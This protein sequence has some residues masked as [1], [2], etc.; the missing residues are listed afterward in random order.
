MFAAMLATTVAATAAIT[1]TLTKGEEERKHK[2]RV[3]RQYQRELMLK[4][5]TVVARLANKEPPRGK[6]ID[7][8]FI[9]KVYLW[10]CQDLRKSFDSA[11]ITNEMKCQYIKI[12]SPVRA[13]HLEKHGSSPSTPYI[14]LIT[15]HECILGEVVRKPNK[16]PRTVAYMRAGPRR[17][18][19]FDPKTVNAAIVTCGG[20]CPGLNNVIRE[21]TKS[22]HQL[23]GIG[24][25]VYGIQGGFRGFYDTK[26]HLQPII[27][28]PEV[29]EN[30]HHQG[31]TI[32]GSSRGGFDLEKILD[33][34]HARNIKQLYVI[35]GDGTHRGAFC[36]HEGCMERGYD[37]S[38][39]GIPKTID[40]DVDYIDRSFGFDSA[41]EA[42][43]VAIRS[44][45][46]EAV[47]NLPNGIGIV[48][49]M[50]R[51]SGYIAAFAT[52]AS[53]DVDL[54][55]VPEVPIVLEGD[56]GCLPHLMR[57]VH[58]QGYAVVVVAEGAGEE[59][60]GTSTEADAS[61]NKKLPP[62]GEFMQKSIEKYFADH[63]EV[64]TVKYIDPSYTI[65]SVPANAADSLYCMQLGQ[66]A[67]HGAM[68]GY[69]GFSVGL[70]NNRMV[71]L[72][73][74]EL[75]ATSPR[76]MNPNGRT[77]ERI[78]ALTRQP[79]TVPGAEE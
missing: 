53:S 1:Y 79:N 56:K 3:Y 68:A 31:G 78:L 45:K 20:L 2:A 42:A 23:Y 37:V 72:P 76:S 13:P 61:G 36:V 26:P 69:T 21:I 74:P 77:W 14:H 6:L 62:I 41:V 39:A 8:V 7:D 54:C 70:C 58:Q 30:I 10:E 49:L 55:L 5:K 60:L 67:V 48:K 25:T 44:A 9:D 46:T 11:N 18:L 63:G 50:G 65:R 52:M 47:C 28:T 64:A 40:N 19:H 32:L 66:N 34:I 73:I 17:Y 71:F 59:V 35:G 27:L 57:R 15:D 43:Q 38:V 51:S 4:E 33:F 24:G 16:A 22:L 75:V 12:R 29:V